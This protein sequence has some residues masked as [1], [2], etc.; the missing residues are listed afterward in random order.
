MT[1]IIYITIGAVFGGFLIWSI[2]TKSKIQLVK[3]LWEERGTGRFGLIMVNSGYTTKGYIEVEELQQA[4]NH[5]KVR[6]IKVYPS[7]TYT[8]SD[9]LSQI[10]AK[11]KGESWVESKVIEWQNNASQYMRDKRLG[12]IL[13][14]E[15]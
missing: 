7:S 8:E 2:M 3:S 4:G 12:D 13:D 15:K 11:G 10:N 6:I 5:I 1:E 14:K 9:C